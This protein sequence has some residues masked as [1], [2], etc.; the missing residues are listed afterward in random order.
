MSANPVQGKLFAATKG[1]Q[2]EE[3]DRKRSSTDRGVARV[4]DSTR[5]P[6]GSGQATRAVNVTSTP[7]SH[8]LVTKTFTTRVPIG[9]GN[10]KSPP[11]TTYVH[12][13]TPVGKRP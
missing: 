4:V 6:V 1:P 11:S 2:S 7:S 5:A 3:G 8:P 12:Q 13:R 9:A 10:N